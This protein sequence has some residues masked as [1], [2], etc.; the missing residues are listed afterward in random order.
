MP[1][2][3]RNQVDLAPTSHD[4]AGKLPV[5]RAAQTMCPGLR[6]PTAGA[7]SSA[8]TPRTTRTP[9]PRPSAVSNIELR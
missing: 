2:S 9:P 4:D 5:P 7:A 6:W 3:A 1:L 8:T